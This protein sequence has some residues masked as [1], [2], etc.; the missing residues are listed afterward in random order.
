M[1]TTLH[2]HLM[3]RRKTFGINASRDK[4]TAS[5]RNQIRLCLGFVGDLIPKNAH[6]LFTAHAFDF[7]SRD[8]PPP[9]TI[10]LEV[11][12]SLEY[13]LDGLLREIEFS[14]EIIDNLEAVIVRWRV[15]SQ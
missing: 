12:Q 6:S 7:S 15:N 2:W 9:R 1:G 13:H 8:I 3:N 11:F 5:T 14:A 10:I 4:S